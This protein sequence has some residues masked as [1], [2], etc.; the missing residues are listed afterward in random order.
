[1]GRFAE[2]SDGPYC[3]HLQGQF[4]HLPNFE[5]K[6]EAS[7]LL[8]NID[9][10]ASFYDI[11]TWNQNPLQTIVPHVLRNVPAR[12]GIWRLIT[13]FRHSYSGFYPDR[14]EFSLHSIT[15]L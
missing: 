12:R 8:C 11:N 4:S 14:V 15:F 13:F 3:F 7:K 9:N 10:T 1:V 2:V 5:L 6:R